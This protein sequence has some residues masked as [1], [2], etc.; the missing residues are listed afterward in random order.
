MYKFIQK[1]QKKFLAV[2]GVLLMI[3][4]ILPTSFKNNINRGDQTI[5]ILD[6]EKITGNE[7]GQARNDLELLRQYEFMPLLELGGGDN[8]N[9]VYAKYF[10][11]DDGALDYLLLQ[12]EAEKQGFAVSPQAAEALAGAAFKN[13][14][15]SP[16][17]LEQM[18][19]VVGRFMLV[20][21]AFERASE[22]VKVSK[23]LLQ[24]YISQAFQGSTLNL[25]EYSAAEMEKSVPAPTPQ[26]VLEQ[27]A[28]YGDVLPKPSIMGLEPATPGYEV[29]DRVKLQYLELPR[30]AIV[31]SVLKELS[32][33]ELYQL[34]LEG[35]RYY[36]T[37]Q[38]EFPAPPALQPQ[39][40]SSLPTTSTAATVP[41]T[42]PATAPAGPTTKPFD[43]VKF[44]LRKRLLTD[45]ALS[46]ADFVVALRDRVNAREKQLRTALHDQLEH[47]YAQW[48]AA[49]TGASA[50]TQ[51]AAATQTVLGP[52][53][54]TT[55][56]VLAT[57]PSLDFL[58]AFANDFEAQY[59][60]RPLVNS[61]A[62]KWLT[63]DDLDSMSDIKT[64]RAGDLSF[65]AYALH[66]LVATPATAPASQPSATNPATVPA[67]TGPAA[68]GPATG[69]T[70]SIATTIPS[71]NPVE[72]SPEALESWHPV[73]T[74]LHPFQPSDLLQDSAG[75]TYV[76]RLT[77]FEP[78]H[79]PPLADVEAKIVEQLKSA[80]G[81]KRA[82][83]EADKLLANAQIE[84][85]LRKEQKLPDQQGLPAAAKASGKQ[86]IQTGPFEVRNLIQTRT[87]PHYQIAD[88]GDNVKLLLAVMHLVKEQ[89]AENPH[90]STVIELP[91]EQKVLVAEMGDTILGHEAQFQGEDFGFQPAPPE[92]MY[93]LDE[94]AAI[95]ARRVLMQ[96]SPPAGQQAA[97]GN[98]LLQDWFD[99][100]NVMS[101]VKYV[102]AKG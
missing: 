34:D 102:K 10:H 76:F 69:P 50:A 89:T 43:E 46:S 84:A 61:L 75:N 78:A 14:S 98:N 35:F 15:M 5:G 29:P 64:A 19:P 2:F 83:D 80:A 77:A 57:Y 3:V 93:S 85:K 95:L 92:Q 82:R 31:Q 97:S 52:A 47:A 59:K 58:T 94:A 23:P 16:T 48:S 96:S 81:L 56:S 86:L 101:R 100:N 39:L 17:L 88:P 20:Q 54:P 18:T 25:V 63:Q 4:F 49:Q 79:R 28:R 87:I 13:M 68:T 71:T 44:E 26:Q 91:D 37:H 55:N 99:L 1:N 60:V 38:S 6:G 12:K 70:T 66:D 27:Y 36:D 24:Y 7:L 40:P 45:P 8:R 32:P 41:A 30:D 73:G 74:G 11:G 72:P 65:P 33:A 9:S 21:G 51:P 42:R 90:P 53:L 67:T 22:S 62:N